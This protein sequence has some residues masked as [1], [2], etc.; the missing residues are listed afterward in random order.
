MA[1]AVLM[2]FSGSNQRNAPF[3]AHTGQLV[4]KIRMEHIIK[5]QVGF[6]SLGQIVFRI[7][8]EF[9]QVARDID[10]ADGKLVSPELL[11]ALDLFLSTPTLF[12][13]NDLFWIMI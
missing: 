4:G 13:N 1:P 7:I 6:K 9:R 12:K 10:R 5:D 3:P 8:D 11:D 2:F